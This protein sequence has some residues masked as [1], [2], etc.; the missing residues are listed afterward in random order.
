LLVVHS[1]H[2]SKEIDEGA[3]A[4]AENIRK[5]IVSDLINLERSQLTRVNSIILSVN[6]CIKQTMREV[7]HYCLSIGSENEKVTLFLEGCFSETSD[8]FCKN[9]NRSTAE[10][11]FFNE[12]RRTQA[13]SQ[14][15][16]EL[17]NK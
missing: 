3:Y 8:L 17:F 1:N 4:M 14:Y 10:T 11:L 15:V 12:I 9:V 16:S 2:N 6:E 7:E 13:F 5:T